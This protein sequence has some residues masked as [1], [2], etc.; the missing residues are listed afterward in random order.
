MS[1]NNKL[2]TYLMWSG[3]ALAGAGAIGLLLITLVFIIGV[4]A[5]LSGEQRTILI[6]ITALVGLLMGMSLVMQGITLSKKEN[7]A[8]L[9]EYFSYFF[10]SKTRAL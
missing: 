6:I 8:T 7:E 3:A 2:K 5:G 9:N 4:Q 1:M 10:K